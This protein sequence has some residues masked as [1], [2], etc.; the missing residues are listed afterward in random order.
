MKLDRRHGAVVCLDVDQLRALAEL[1]QDLTVVLAKAICK[2]V[3]RE[4][5]HRMVDRLYD[6][7]MTGG[8]EG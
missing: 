5:V 8:L 1:R 4:E 6:E 3:S 2:N 7:Y